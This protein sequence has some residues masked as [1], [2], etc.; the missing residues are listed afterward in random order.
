MKKIAQVLL[1]MIAAWLGGLI[2]IFTLLYFAN[3]G[4][5]FTRA[6]LMG[7]S[8][9]FVVA[10]TLLMLGVYLPAFNSASCDGGHQP[11]SLPTSSRSCEGLIGLVRWA[12]K[13]ARKERPRSS[14]SV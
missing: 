5:D 2:V 3:G 13:P 6:D 8:V 12:S 9:L 10:S 11:I 4:A 14:Y 1:A 7:F